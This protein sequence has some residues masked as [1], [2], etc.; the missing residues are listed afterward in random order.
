MVWPV[1][2]KAIGRMT[3]GLSPMQQLLG[4]LLRKHRAQERMLGTMG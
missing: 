3:G 1:Q 4:L 2:V